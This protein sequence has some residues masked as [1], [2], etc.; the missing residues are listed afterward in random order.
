MERLLAEGVQA[1]EF[2][3]D[4]DPHVAA[5][6]ILAAVDGIIVETIV[7]GVRFGK[8]FVQAFKRGVSAALV[9]GPAM[10]PTGRKDEGDE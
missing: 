1:G 2:H 6:L 7:L 8:G 5:T 9:S 10:G 4:L 3:P